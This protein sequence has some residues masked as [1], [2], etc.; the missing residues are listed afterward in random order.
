MILV[1][2]GI[3]LDRKIPFISKLKRKTGLRESVS[4]IKK[5]EIVVLEACDWNPLFTT[6]L[7][8]LEFYLTQ[9]VVF[10][11]DQIER[12]ENVPEEAGA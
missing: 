4:Q 6:P 2:K 5:L 11:S 10:S 8:L 12:N 9:G 3:E 7:E 1:A